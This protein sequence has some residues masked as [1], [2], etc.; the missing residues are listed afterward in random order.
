MLDLLSE[1]ISNRVENLR[2][3][4]FRRYWKRLLS[5]KFLLSITLSNLITNLFLMHLIQESVRFLVFR[6][7]LLDS[8][9]EFGIFSITPLIIFPIRSYSASDTESLILRPEF[10]AS[11]SVMRCFNNSSSD[12]MIYI[13]N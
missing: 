8:G 6:F 11:S 3:F 9:L 13:Y 10:S 4:L 2:P 5:L 7:Q 12:D 1:L